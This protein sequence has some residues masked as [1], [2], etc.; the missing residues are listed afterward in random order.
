M[1]GAQRLQEATGF[2]Q[3]AWLKGGCG[4]V[5]SIVALVNISTACFIW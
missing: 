5:S 2:L 3:T 4:V 1:V